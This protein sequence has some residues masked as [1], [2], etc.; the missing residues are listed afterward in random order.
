MNHHSNRF[1]L[2]VR[3]SRWSEAKTFRFGYGCDFKCRERSLLENVPSAPCGRVLDLLR[4]ASAV[5]FTDRIIRRDRRGGPNTWS[6]TLS[7]AF[8]VAD[9]DFWSAQT[10]SERLHDVL[11]FVSGDEWTIRFLPPVAGCSSGIEWQPPLASTFF[12]SNPRLC[13]YSGGLDS[14]AGLAHQLSLPDERPIVPITVR[15]RSDLEDKVKHQLLSLGRQS[16]RELHSVVVPFEMS[17]PSKLVQSEE[18][19]Q[20]SRA[21]LFVAV[22]AAVADGFNMSE[23]EM[24]ESGVGAINVPLLAGMEGSQATRGSHPHFLQLVSE[25]L[26]LVVGRPFHVILPFMNKTKGELVASLSRSD[27]RQIANDTCSC[28]SFPVRV[29]QAGRQQSCGVCAACL[30]RR[31][32]MHTAGIEE[33]SGDYQYDFLSRDTTIP[34]KKR[35]Y[36]AAFLNQVDCLNQTDLRK[37]PLCIEKHLRQTHIINDGYSVE[38]VVDLFCRYRDEWLGLIRRAESIG[39]KWTKLINLP[40]KAA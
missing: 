19:S 10:I 37:L 13:L 1:S 24:F 7:L 2:E 18:T 32:A 27:L 26:T 14:A 3:D 12:P 21:F 4:I 22:G 6:R 35:R 16:G 20:R 30:F 34:P 33:D 29:H 39:C 25:L 17:S 38:T 36:L 8:E 9:T 23:L 28:P 5:F 11:R 15:H 40:S 31:L